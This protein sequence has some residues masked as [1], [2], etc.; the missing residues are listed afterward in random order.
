MGHYDRGDHIV[1]EK[2][3]WGVSPDPRARKIAP[4]TSGDLYSYV[5]DKFWVVLAR[6][7]SGQLRIRTRTGKEFL[8]AEN[9]EHLRRPRLMERMLLR[10]RF[11]AFNR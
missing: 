5:V 11:P 1:Y 10:S 8:I 3:K 7:D 4:A 2:H 6:L 9:D